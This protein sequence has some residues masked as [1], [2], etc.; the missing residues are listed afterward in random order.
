MRKSLPK[1]A[2][3]FVY[4]S[5]LKSVFWMEWCYGD[6][7]KLQYLYNCKIKGDYSTLE[8]KNK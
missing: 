2:Y 6:V 3:R 5:G 7:E 1:Y 4:N 8:W